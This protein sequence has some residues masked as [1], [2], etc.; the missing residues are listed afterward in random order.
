MIPDAYAPNKT[1]VFGDDYTLGDWRALQEFSQG[2]PGHYTMPCCGAR[3]IPKTSPNG[4]HHFA[5][6]GSECANA[7]ETIWHQEAKD[8]VVGAIKRLG[9]EGIHELSGVLG[10]IAGELM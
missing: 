10:R 6:Y 9:L 7:P 4:V 2:N 8:L 5:H 3:A 1:P